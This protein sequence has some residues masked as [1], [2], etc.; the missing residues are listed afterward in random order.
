MAE[1]HA[2]PLVTVAMPVYNAGRDLRAAVLSVVNQTY[3]HWEML[4]IDDGSSDGSLDSIND[5]RDARIRV[6]RDGCNRGLA[7]RLNEAI[8]LA[9]GTYLARMDQDDVSFPGRFARQ[10]ASLRERPDLDLV[11]V[12]AMTI[13]PSDELL[14]LFPR[15]LS[16]AQICSRPWRGFYLPHPTWMG[17]IE[18]FRRFRYRI[19]ESYKS[20]D[21]E[22]LLR[23]YRRSTFGCVDEVLFAYRVRGAIRLRASLRTR[24]ALLRV[25]AATF[26]ASRQFGWVCLACAV[27]GLRVAKDAG[28]FLWQ[29]SGARFMRPRPSPESRPYA[30]QWEQIRRSA[31]PQAC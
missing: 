16:H 6:L 31:S 30:A 13:S 19:P 4:I 24:W 15:A 21:Q 22:L 23:S 9:R 26:A 28:T 27:C 10:V 11:A 12:R 3:V 8:D 14:G 20:D 2:E 18:W 5:I 1:P 29:A 25:Q 7:A 17:R